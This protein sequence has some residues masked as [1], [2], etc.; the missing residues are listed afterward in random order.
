MERDDDIV[1]GLGF[2]ALY[3][4][5]VEESID[6]I[7]ERLSKVE[8]ITDSER[9]LPISKKIK[10]CKRVLCSFESKELEELVNLLSETKKLLEKR[11]EI[12]HGR[13]YSGNERSDTLKSGRSSI[14]ERDVTADELYDLADQLLEMQA[15]IPNRAFHATMRALAGRNNA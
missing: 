11:N 4:A 9:K 1:R 3:A 7:M 2:V 6:V 8:E 5:Y 12:V 10:W 14:P 13:I 15:A